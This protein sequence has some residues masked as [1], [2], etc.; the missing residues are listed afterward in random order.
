MKLRRILV[1]V[2]ASPHSLAACEA[3]A[4][5]AAL[6]R[7]EM[8]AV[9]VKDTDL[10]RLAGLPFAREMIYPLALG[11][12]IESS[13]MESRLRE[14]A[15]LARRA[16]SE[17]ALRAGIDWLFLVR[18]GAVLTELLKA[19]EESDLLVLGK[20]SHMEK[21][22]RVRL[23]TTAANLLARAVRPV[24]VLQHGEF[25]GGPPLLVTDGSPESVAQLPAAVTSAAIFKGEPV[26]L[27]LAKDR[28]EAT[29][30]KR[31]LE[32]EP[33]L[34]GLRFRR[35]AT[36]EA[37]GMVRIAHEEEAGVVI[38]VGFPFGITP[39]LLPEMLDRLDRP[40]LVFR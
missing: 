19:S 24:L 8:V 25:F 34:K 38:F 36:A 27:I 17:H 6:H 15:E 21:G 10:V 30:I 11:R 40:V 20:A 7:A 33:G 2:D 13:M 31:K 28:D 5:L 35:C 1:A 16:V 22:R 26:V 9:F 37:A 32:V 29:A 39:E 23:G 18:H 14:L 3:A 12:P 4:Q